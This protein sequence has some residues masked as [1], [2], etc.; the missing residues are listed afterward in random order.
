MAT[1]TL[2]CYSWCGSQCYHFGKQC[3]LVKLN[4]YLTAQDLRL[5]KLLCRCLHPGSVYR[6]G[7]NS[8][9]CSNQKGEQESQLLIYSKMNKRSTPA[10]RNSVEPEVQCRALY[11]NMDASRKSCWVKEASQKRSAWGHLYKVHNQEKLCIVW[12]FI[13][14]K[15]LKKRITNIQECGF[16]GGGV[17]GNTG[18]YKQLTMGTFWPL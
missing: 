17:K 16:L 3:R 11:I 2:I 7:H 1:A 15:T 8:I 10:Q 6:N 18:A 13:S 9:I 4:R 14:S 5:E 12:G